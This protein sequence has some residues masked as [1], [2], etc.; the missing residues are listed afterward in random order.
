M[1]KTDWPIVRVNGILVEW[2]RIT[3]CSL[4]LIPFCINFPYNNTDKN[5]FTLK[6]F[7]YYL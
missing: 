5:R 6:L 4:G 2:D 7:F 3:V 1:R